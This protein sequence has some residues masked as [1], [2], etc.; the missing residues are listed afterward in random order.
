MPLSVA[1][2]AQPGENGETPIP[3]RAGTGDRDREG[4]AR[5]QTGPPGCVRMA[6]RDACNVTPGG[7][8]A[9]FPS[10]VFR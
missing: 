2:A 10:G 6:A 5:G 4:P 9:P 3:E 8:R 7:A 1:R